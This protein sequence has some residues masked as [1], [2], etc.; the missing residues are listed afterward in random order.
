MLHDHAGLL[1]IALDARRLFPPSA[2]FSVA[3]DLG[4]G[5]DETIVPVLTPC[6]ALS[7]ANFTRLTAVPPHGQTHRRRHLRR[8]KE[9]PLALRCR[10]A[11]AV[12]V[13]APIAE[14]VDERFRAMRAMHF[15]S[16]HALD[17]FEKF[18]EVGVI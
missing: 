6:D 4:Q 2:D 17:R 8:L 9:Q 10:H 7:P 14:F 15:A 5:P 11:Q 3:I 13:Y 16:I 1:A 12:G 18:I